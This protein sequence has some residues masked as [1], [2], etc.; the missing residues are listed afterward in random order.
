MISGILVIGIIRKVLVILLLAPSLIMTLASQ[1]KH[2]ANLS[3]LFLRVLTI[4][5]KVDG[6]EIG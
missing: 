1:G 6:L 5:F 2:L 4:W 3:S